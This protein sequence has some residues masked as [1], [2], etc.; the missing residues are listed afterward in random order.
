MEFHSLSELDAKM[1]PETLAKARELYEKESMAMKLK[2]MRKKYAVKQHDMQGFS[3]AAVSKM[4]ARK[5]MRVFTLLRYVQDL[6]MGLEIKAI[7]PDPQAAPEVLLHVNAQA[8]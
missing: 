8:Q 4:E 7:P 6:G 3:Q 1:K 2:E 5:D